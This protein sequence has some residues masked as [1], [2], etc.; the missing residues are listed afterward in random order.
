MTQRF[1]DWVFTTPLDFSDSE[2]RR[3]HQGSFRVLP[4]PY[5]T[6][7]AF[8]VVRDDVRE[9]RMLEL[10]YLGTE[11]TVKGTYAGGAEIEYGR[12]SFRPTSIFVHTSI[13]D[14][15]DAFVRKI[16]AARDSFVRVLSSS[17]SG[18]LLARLET[19]VAAIRSTVRKYQ[20]ELSDF[21]PDG[22]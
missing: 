2:V 16:D 12:R 1:T 17:V 10:R 8:R 21:L 6:P 3:L 11:P 15:S 9:G 14:G 13:S 5:I 18:V 4:S 19:S 22:S 20:A 7:V